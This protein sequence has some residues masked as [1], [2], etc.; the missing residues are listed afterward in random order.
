[1]GNKSRTKKEFFTRLTFF[2]LGLLI[3]SLGITLTIKAKDLGI[4][5]WDVFHYGL[6]L[7]FGLTV[8]TWSII[9]GFS[10]VFI[11]ACITKSFPKMGTYINMILIGLFIDLFN[12]MIPDIHLLWLEIV[13][14]IVGIVFTAIGVGL[15]VA[16]DFGAGPRDSVMINLSNQTGW[17]V[18]HVRSGIELIVFL[19]GWL[20]GGP[21][22]L[23][24]VAIVLFLGTVVGY[25][26]PMAK[27][28]MD[29]V[30]RRGEGDENFNQRSL[31]INHNDR[32]S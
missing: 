6:Y 29:F 1:M 22:G 23:G 9:A 14:L 27:K 24:T 10:I 20:L 16:P 19:L 4:S 32:V 25:T 30:I 31:R 21:V 2:M 5:P 11:T 7:Q 12:W 3:L 15:Y 8:G 13:L 26:I 28:L 17:K 18:S